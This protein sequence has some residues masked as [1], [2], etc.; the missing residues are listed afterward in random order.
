MSCPLPF[1]EQ[2]D[3]SALSSFKKCPTDWYWSNLR[4][5]ALKGGSIHL[6]S[7]GAFAAGLE[8]ARKSFYEQGEPA[9]TALARGLHA[10][11]LFYGDFEAPEDHLKAFPRLVQ[12]LCSYFEQYPL[13]QDGFTPLELPSGSAIEFTFAI[14]LPINNPDTGEP[15]LYTGR[16]D[17]LGKWNGATFGLDDKT[18]S[19]LGPSW[20]RNWTLDS[21]FT[22]Y[23]WATRTFGISTAGFLVRGISFLKNG[24]GHAQAIVYRPQ[25][26]IDRWYESMLFTVR[27]MIAYH[28][29]G[30]FPLTLDKHACNSYGG[31]PYHMLCE[32]KDPEVWIEENYIP[33]V[34]NPLTKGGSNDQL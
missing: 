33:K 9:E 7:G 19:Q 10:M 17:A 25:W 4:Q 20:T 11:T 26:Q 14:P 15:L 2:I 5:L 13:E 21:Q 29:E 8:G 27:T 3:N 18:A 28:Q 30:F 22:G 12:A 23:A 24:F 31:C 34:W 16:F 6:H 32:S 1:P